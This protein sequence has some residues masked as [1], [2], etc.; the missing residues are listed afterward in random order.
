MGTSPTDHTPEPDEETKRILEERLK[1]IDEDMKMARPA[2]EVL[3]ELRAELKA[4][5][6]V[7]GD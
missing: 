5:S 7:A 3:E 6:L 4:N 2:K 1:T